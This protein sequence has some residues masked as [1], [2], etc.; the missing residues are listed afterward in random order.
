MRLPTVLI[1]NGAHARKTVDLRQQVAHRLEG[2]T[3]HGALWMAGLPKTMQ[4]IQ[5]AWVA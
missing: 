1:E 2:E 4:P 3:L 5:T